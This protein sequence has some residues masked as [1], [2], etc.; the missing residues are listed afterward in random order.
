MNFKAAARSWSIVQSF[1]LAGCAAADTAQSDLPPDAS[2]VDAGDVFERDGGVE[3]ASA[4]DADSGRHRGPRAD[5]G[6]GE[7]SA[8]VEDIWAGPAMTCARVNRSGVV[9]TK[10]WGDNRAAQLGRGEASATGVETFVPQ[11]IQMDDSSQVV[12]VRST[13]DN[14]YQRA[15]TCIVLRDKTLKCWGSR[16]DSIE[17]LTGLVTAPPEVPLLTGVEDVRMGEQFSCARLETSNVACWGINRDGQLG[18][19]TRDYTPHELPVTIPNFTADEIALSNHL[20]CGRK[21]GDVW[22]WGGLGLSSPFGASPTQ[23]ANLH[24]VTQ[25][26]GGGNVICALASDSTIWCWAADGAMS[27]LLDPTEAEPQRLLDNVADFVM[28]SKAD[29]L[30]LKMKDGT[31]R[32]RWSGNNVAIVTSTIEGVVDPIRVVLGQSHQCAIMADETVRCWG[33]NIFGQLAVDPTLLKQ[34]SL[35][36]KVHL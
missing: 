10:C 35:S 30:F 1:V 12:A 25:I 16:W 33:S 7:D 29:S 11:A 3:D 9:T 19:G 15:Q 26:R 24:G 6:S 27:H 22:C 14:A 5:A 32:L 8:V 21:G 2:Q 17:P 4:S 34:S 20:G 31:V 18:L 36:V 28:G 13:T 23:V